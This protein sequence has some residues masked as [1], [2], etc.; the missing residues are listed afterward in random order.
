MN[1]DQVKGAAKHISGE[2]QQQVGKLTGDTDTRVRGH[3]KEA[4]G[5][6]QKNVGDARESVRHSEREL[7]QDRERQ[8]KLDLDR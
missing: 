3:A 6:L 1:K 4:E 7:E 2:V 8:R 5:K